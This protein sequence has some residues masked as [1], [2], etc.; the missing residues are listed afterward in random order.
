MVVA[1]K[2]RGRSGSHSHTPESCPPLPPWG[3]Q[4][5]AEGQTEGSAGWAAESEKWLW[6]VW[7]RGGSWVP[8]PAVRALQREALGLPRGRRAG[9]AAQVGAVGSC[10]MPRRVGVLSVVVSGR[11]VTPLVHASRGQ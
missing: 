7:G 5:E 10:G 6:S 2:R 8:G 11:G 9:R 3:C 4:A 1:V